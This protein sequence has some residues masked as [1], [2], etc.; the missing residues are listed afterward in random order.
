MRDDIAYVQPIEAI[1]DPEIQTIWEAFKCY[2][3]HVMP[4]Q[5]HYTPTFKAQVTLELLKEEKTVTQIAAE[6]GIHPGQ[7]H[8]W[9]RQ[10]LDNFLHLFTESS[11]LQRQ[12]REHEAQLA[13]LYAQI[14]K[15]TTQLE[16]LK[17]KSG[18]DPVSH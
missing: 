11:D 16:W 9:K 1:V 7:L 14:G 18:L 2:T 10:A 13:E 12:A 4:K 6:Q 15:L 17:K 3:G 5:K 8:R